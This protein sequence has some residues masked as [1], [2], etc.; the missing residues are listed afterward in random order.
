M[1]PE[2]AENPKAAPGPEAAQETAP[3]AAPSPGAAKNSD[4]ERKE[5]IQIPDIDRDSL[6][7]LP[8]SIVPLQTPS[9]RRARMIKNVRL[10]SVIE[11]FEEKQTG[12]GQMEIA[13]IGKE[14]GWPKDKPVPDRDILQTLGALH[15]YDVYSLRISLREHNIPVNDIEA[16]KLSPAKNAELTEYMTDFTRPL[17]L[18]IYG[19]GDQD[20]KNFDDVIALFRDPDVRKARDKLEVMAAKLEIKL[21]EVPRF[22]EDYGDIFLS[23][24]YYRQC[25][26]EIEPIISGFL[27]TME[28]LR[29]NWQLRNDKNLMKTCTEI[30]ETINGLMAAITGRFENFDRST[31]DMWNNISAE[32]FRRVKELIEGYHTTIGGVL[33]ALSVK[34]DAWARLFPNKDTGGPVRRAEFIMSEIKQGIDNIQEIEDSAPML[35]LLD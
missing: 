15:S 8:L 17:I 5:T 24:S 7:T 32:R 13:D 3:D 25:L 21:S 12:S 6:H 11:V 10:R 22:L 28:D 23:L 30:E 29:S 20:I 33:C 4:S 2:A 19:S 9:L 16:L 14:F 31:K 18:Q 35:S 27:E 1:E 26:D 34:M